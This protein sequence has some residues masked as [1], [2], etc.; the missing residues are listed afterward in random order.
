MW[1]TTCATCTT[2]EEGVAPGLKPYTQHETVFGIDHQLSEHLAFEVRWDRRR[3]DHVIEDAALY[4]PN[5]GETFVIVNPG[6][7]ANSTFDGF[8]NFLYGSPSGCVPAGQTATPPAANCPNPPPLASRAYDGVEFRLTKTPTHHW[9]GTF[10]YTWSNFRGNYT[11][12]TNTDISDGGGGR[13]APNNSRAFDEPFFYYDAAGKLNNGPLPT[14]RPSVFKGYAYYELPWGRKFST[15]FGIFQY[16][17]QGSPV[18]S[19]VDVGL[20]AAPTIGANGNPNAEVGAFPTY[21]LPRGQYLPISQD[22]SGNITFGTPYNRRTP[23]FIQSDL[24]V[25]PTYKISENKSLSFS[26]TAPNVFN[27]HAVTAYWQGIDTD[28]YPQFLA[29]PSAACGGPCWLANGYQFYAAAMSGYDY[30]S[31]INNA[32]GATGTSGAMTI[33][34]LY[35]KPLYRQLTRNLYMSVKFTF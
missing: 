19:F 10:S 33:G 3:L 12:L 22:A 23:W 13:N 4:N 35:G 6:Q 29:P 11:G 14:D 30:K 25:T 9:A 32:L 17:Y 27:Q 21:I 26:V 7:G 15:N 1:P 24:Q 8:W 5:I 28:Y 16:L 31:L 34:S 20:S 2:T 18:S